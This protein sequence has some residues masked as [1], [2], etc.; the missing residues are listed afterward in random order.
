[1]S[2]LRVEDCLIPEWPAPPHVKALITTRRGGVSTGPYA[3]LNLGFSTEDDPDA[4]RTNRARLAALLPQEPRWL[5]QV[6][7][8]HVVVADTMSARLEADASVAREAGSVCAILIADCLPVLFTDRGGTVVAAAHAGWRGL[9]AGVLDQTVAILAQR[10]A[11]CSELLAYIGPGIGPHA[12]EVGN[13]VVEAFV[14]RDAGAQSA[15]KPRSTGKWLGDLFT[16]AR[17]ALARCG[18]TRV[19]GG[20]VCTYSEPARFFSHR[21]DRTTGRM[22]ALIWIDR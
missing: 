13:E 6:H 11:D 17:R 10:G 7:G 2:D 8:A 1:M 20:G 5:R 15:F 14:E 3:S 18:V 19:Y 9:A 21:R 4:V 12:F 22:A 16:L